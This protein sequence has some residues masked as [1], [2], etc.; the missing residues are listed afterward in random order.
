M[1]LACD[2]QHSGAMRAFETEEL[3]EVSKEHPSLKNLSLV[4]NEYDDEDLASW[5]GVFY[6]PRINSKFEKTHTCTIRDFYRISIIS[7][8]LGKTQAK[9]PRFNK[10]SFQVVA[11]F[12]VKPGGDASELHAAVRGLRSFWSLAGLF[13]TPCTG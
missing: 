4:T 3:A 8:S 13:P 12:Q 2:A 10:L 5:E 6:H 1:V 7:I 9:P 11:A